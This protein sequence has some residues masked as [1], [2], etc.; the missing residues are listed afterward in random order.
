MSAL[1]SE[2]ILESQF[3][4]QG[5]KNYNTSSFSSKENS[6]QEASENG[7]TQKEIAEEVIARASQE[8]SAATNSIESMRKRFANHRLVTPLNSPPKKERK[9]QLPKFSNFSD[10]NANPN[11][12]MLAVP[13]AAEDPLAAADFGKIVRKCALSKSL[14]KLLPVLS[15]AEIDQKCKALAKE[16]LKEKELSFLCGLG[17][18]KDRNVFIGTDD[19]KAKAKAQIIAFITGNQFKPFCESL[20]EIFS[21]LPLD[22]YFISPSSEPSFFSN[23]KLEINDFYFLMQLLESKGFYGVNGREICCWSGLEANEMAKKSPLVND[24]QVPLIAFLHEFARHFTTDTKHK[25]ARSSKFSMEEV[26]F[27][28]ASAYFVHKSSKTASIVF[29]TSPRKDSEKSGLTVGN[30]FWNV[31]LRIIRNSGR[32]VKV[33]RYIPG[34]DDI[35]GYWM[36]PQLLE[37]IDEMSVYRRTPILQGDL[38]D[39][40]P[41]LFERHG[42]MTSKT[43]FKEFAKGAAR[44]SIDIE[45]VKLVAMQWLP[46]RKLSAR[47]QALK[48]KFLERWTKINNVLIAQAIRKSAS[49]ALDK[50]SERK[51]AVKSM[52]K[53]KKDMFKASVSFF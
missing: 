37:T 39:K 41:S 27:L 49:T 47:S 10:E 22:S 11:V 21:V 3:K 34:S 46:P 20:Y 38:S 12:E 5:T 13:K 4:N 45:T 40:D 29:F 23:S 51:I 35:P 24:G 16:M 2:L 6:L 25:P 43:Q 18:F 44:P 7:K 36:E 42:Q 50:E 26:G 33:S 30:F 15:D 17:L 53:A 14:D 31:E 52:M 1:Q 28:A 48:R 19:E 32:S 8:G 9:S